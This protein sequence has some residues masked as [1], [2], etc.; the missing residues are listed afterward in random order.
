MPDSDQIKRCIDI[1]EQWSEQNGMTLN[2]QKSGIVVFAPRMARD[3][4][5]MVLEKRK[6]EKDKDH[7][8]AD[9]IPACKDIQ[10]V[11]IVSNYKYLGTLLD[12]KVTMKAQQK[13]I[14]RKA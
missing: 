6:D 14:K 8:I 10:G 1:I 7:I 11:P 2:K 4:P 12:T 9:W 5:L 3:V 13:L